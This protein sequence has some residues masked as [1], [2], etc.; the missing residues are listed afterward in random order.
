M[1]DVAPPVPDESSKDQL[2]TL[3]TEIGINPATIEMVVNAGF[4]TVT[5][6]VATSP[7]Q[8]AELTGMDRK[9]AEDLHMAVQK[10]VWFGGI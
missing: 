3:L 5:E 9:S 7:D 8:I 2:R 1:P 4:A 10:Q 6:L